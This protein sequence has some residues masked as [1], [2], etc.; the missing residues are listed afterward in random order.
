VTPEATVVVPT[1][2]HGELLLRSVGCALAQTVGDLEVLIVG[3]GA[4][5]E[6]R[7]AALQLERSDARVRFFDNPKGPRLGEVH[8][9][10]ALEQAQ[11]RLVFYL[12]DDD[13]WMPDHVERMTAALDA[14]HADFVHAPPVW[15]MPDGELLVWLVDLA[16][17]WF[18]ELALRESRI[19]L[20]SG[21]HTLAAYR[22]LPVGWNTTP[23]GQ[24]VDFMMWRRFLE[25][26]DMTFAVSRTHTVMHFPGSV[27]EGISNAERADELD[28]WLPATRDLA[29]R[30][31]YLEQLAAHLHERAN[32][33]DSH[34]GELESWAQ[35]RSQVVDLRNEQLSQ[36]ERERQRL[37]EVIRAM[38]S[39]RRWRAG[40]RLRRLSRP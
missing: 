23:E 33:L 19:P 38:K 35:N 31:A 5:E 4:T 26:R 1:H 28:D 24:Y 39:S 29:A 11:G 37:E 36:A 15:V 18:R 25:Q 34:A 8:R 7:E 16:Q 17:P 6:T 30:A 22:R 13:L 20:S 27:R 14:A 10:A 9:A 12:S 2:H 3:D 32:W 21:A 40:E